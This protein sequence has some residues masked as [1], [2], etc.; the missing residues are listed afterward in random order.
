MNRK[1]Y[2]T[3]K[4]GEQLFGNNRNRFLYY[5]DVALYHAPIYC[6]PRSPL[7]KM[8]GNKN[9]RSLF[10]PKGYKPSSPKK[11]PQWIPKYPVTPK[12][13]PEE[14][15]QN[16]E[17][18]GYK[19][20]E[21]R[22][23]IPQPT[24]PVKPNIRL[25]INRDS[26]NNSEK[27]DVT[28][29][30]IIPEDIHPE[31]DDDDAEDNGMPDLEPSEDEKKGIDDLTRKIENEISNIILINKL[32]RAIRPPETSSISTDTSDDSSGNTITNKAFNFQGGDSSN[33]PPIRN[34]IP[35]STLFPM[36][37]LGFGGP[38]FDP[39]SDG[40]PFITSIKKRLPIE[41]TPEEES[42]EFA[43]LEEK[44]DTIDD[45]IRIG[46]LYKEK[47]EPMKKRFNL[48]VR[49]LESLV[50][51][52]EELQKMIGMEKIKMA[53]YEKIILYLQGIENR[54]RDFLHT[55]LYGGPGMGKTEVAKIIGKIY[56]K[57]GLLSKG[58]FKEVRLTDLKAGYVGQS[59]LKTQK[60]LDDAKGCVLFMDEAY[61]L[62][63]D[64][65]FDQFSQGIIDIINPYM[66][67]YKDDFVFIVAGYRD[68]LE[69]RF[70]KGNQ[71]L[72]SRF[73]LWLEI[74]EY[75]GEQ[76]RSIFLKKVADYGWTCKSDEIKA[77]FFEKNKKLF[78][79][80]GRDID[81]CF[82]K[83]KIAHAKRVLY[84]KPEDK[85]IITFGDLEEGFKIYQKDR[86]LNKKD[87][88]FEE[89]KRMMYM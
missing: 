79:F 85:K 4:V 50:E 87:S 43:I 74:D 8:N 16:D 10:S 19:T 71:G 45:L 69:H 9:D 84:L 76:L 36:I 31:N 89:I 64:D 75:N 81:V 42:Y 77:E 68:E 22:T 65:K 13:I 11:K 48:N 28:I 60:V 53:I 23:D 3:I 47:Y 44:A 33:L 82:S 88:A 12:N 7:Y 56:A 20:P 37:K 78:P 18:D 66:D 63:S 67:K 83:C 59:E 38:S 29:I 21:P 72:K 5:D 41:W 24:T 30:E 15:S 39:N 25:S 54:N 34:K 51:P 70:F 40:N 32:L 80:Y 73:G 57:M 55:V 2:L 35:V 86:D 27:P 46:K 52:L 26:T 62:G 49:V 17:E 6:K 14:P 58:D 61:S 1:S